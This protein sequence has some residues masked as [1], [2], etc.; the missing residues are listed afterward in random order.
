MRRRP[1]G[2]WTVIGIG[3]GC[4]LGVAMKQIPIYTGF[5]AV[6]GLLIG[7]IV[8]IARRGAADD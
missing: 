3:M 8:S 4:G 1:L 6:I 2:V 7:S 5:G